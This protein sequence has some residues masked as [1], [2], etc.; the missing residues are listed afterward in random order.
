MET[1]ND[2]LDVEFR[3]IEIYIMK[4]ELMEFVKKMQSEGMLASVEFQDIPTEYERE[5]TG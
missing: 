2:Q 5:L 3:D 1:T 4:I